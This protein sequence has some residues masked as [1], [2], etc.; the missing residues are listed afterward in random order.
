MTEIMIVDDSSFMRRVLR[1]ILTSE[2]YN[3]VAEAESG[4][5]AFLKY[6]KLNP[7]LV[8][9]D[10]IM[11]GKSGIDSAR[12]IVTYNKTAKIIM[13][14]AMGQETQIEEAIQA[15]VKGFI[16]KPFKKEQIISEV[17]RVLGLI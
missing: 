5:N 8:T 14:S 2:G 15:G 7:D 9:M 16:V 3:I 12:E 17:K 1:D 13:I 4:E 11:G 10:L 6:K